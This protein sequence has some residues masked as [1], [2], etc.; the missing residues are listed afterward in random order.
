MVQGDHYLFL[1]F[2]V[3]LQGTG[4]RPKCSLG[5]VLGLPFSLKKNTGVRLR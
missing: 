1:I 2:N 4:D 3:Y 5:E